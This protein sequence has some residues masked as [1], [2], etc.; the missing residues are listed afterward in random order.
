MTCPSNR[1]DILL[2]GGLRGL[3]VAEI[4]TRCDLLD[5]PATKPL[6]GP[7]SRYSGRL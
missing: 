1:P 4:T 3:R 7:R 2:I 5:S 6:V